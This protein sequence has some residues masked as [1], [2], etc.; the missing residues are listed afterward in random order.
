[1]N[2]S[3]RMTHEE[4]KA[5]AVRR[6]GANIM[7]WAFVCPACNYVAKV[8]DWQDAG[9]SEGEVAF[10]CVGRRRAGASEAF[11]AEGPGPCNYAGGGLIGL[12]PQEVEASG[13][14]TRVFAFAPET[15]TNEKS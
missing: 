13:R 2:E 3:T 5:E 9:A 4:W 1:M 12:N 7:D 6:F 10:S 14:V 15:P 11:S 8:Q